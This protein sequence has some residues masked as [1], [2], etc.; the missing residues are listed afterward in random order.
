MPAVP[1]CLLAKKGGVG[2]TS[3]TINLAGAL[4]KEGFK[5]LVV[6]M[7]S[8]ASLTQF[9]LGPEATEQLPKACTIAAAFD[10]SLDSNPHSVVRPTNCEGIWLAPANESLAAHELPRPNA[11]GPLQFALRDFLLEAG[12]PFDFILLDTPPYIYG[13]LAWSSL[14]ASRYVLT[15]LHPETFSAQALIGVQRLIDQAI[16]QGNPQLELLGYVV[17]LKEAKPALHKLTEARVRQL[18]RDQVFTT[19]I[20]KAQAFSD[21]IPYQKPVSEHQPA[22]AAAKTMQKL[23]RE[24]L[25]RIGMEIKEAPKAKG[26]R[27]AA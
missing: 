27:K 14:L 13:M 24:L 3:L 9:F 10:E 20:P 23:A 7:E 11:T 26:R 21:A 19:V 6:D 15:P 18:H 12:Q 22:S 17:N 25:Q 5:I 2:R 4:A 16:Q 1:I 8:Q